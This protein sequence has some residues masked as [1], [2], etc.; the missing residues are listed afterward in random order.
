VPEQS[1]DAGPFVPSRHYDKVEC[2][3][4]WKDISP[5]MAVAY[6]IFGNGRSAFKVNV[7]RYVA[8]DIYTQ[9]RANNPVTRAVLNASRTWTDS[10]N[11]FTPDCDLTNFAAQNLS[12]TGGDVCGGLN[13]VNFGKNNPNATTYL[14]DTLRGFGARL[15]NWQTQVTFDQQL[16][17]NVSLGFGYFR[18]VWSGFAA[19]QNVALSPGLG[20]FTPYCVT[21]PTDA[22]LPGGGGYQI[23]DVYDVVR[24]KFGSTTNVVSR[25]PTENGNQTEVYNGFDIVLNIR[26]PRRININGGLNSGRTVTNNCGLTLTNLQFGSASTPHTREHCEIVPPWLASTQVKFSGAFPLPHDFQVATTFQNLPGIAYGANAPFT[27]AQVA[28]SLGRDLSAGPNGT[29]TIPLLPP[30]RYYEDRIQQVDFRFSRSFRIRNTRVE[31]QFDIYNAFNASP[32]LAVNNTYGPQWRTPT[33]ILA[34]RLLKFGFQMT[35]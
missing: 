20:D 6:D 22:R 30:N 9:A 8:A 14:P 2:V 12:A 28:P 15:H 3:P 7:G 32:I 26:L 4:C 10:N 18:T 34:G 5:R 27:N 16:R 31:P 21:A 29:V 17:H 23:C 35:F 19:T 13:N 33:Q 1:L 11:N 24:T 25:A